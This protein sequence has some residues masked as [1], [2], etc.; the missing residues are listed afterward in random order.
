M[1]TGKHY[2]HDEHLRQQ[3]CTKFLPILKFQNQIAYLYSFHSKTSTDKLCNLST[4]IFAESG[5]V[6]RIWVHWYP[7]T[8]LFRLLES[9]GN[10]PFTISQ[11]WNLCT[12]N[13]RKSNKSFALGNRCGADVFFWA[14]SPFYQHGLTLIPAWIS[15]YMPSEVWDEIIYPF[16][17]FNGCTVEV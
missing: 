8:Q 14:S 15:N 6:T 3:G 9:L 5:N 16:L 10:L 17:N 12:T 13:V 2:I 4:H 7:G 1:V 11:F